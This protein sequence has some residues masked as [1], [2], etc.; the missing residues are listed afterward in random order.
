MQNSSSAS[1][2]GSRDSA[3]SDIGFPEDF[4]TSS[5]CTINDVAQMPHGKDHS[6]ISLAELSN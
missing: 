5:L 3:H 4:L 2:Q 6:Q 1:R